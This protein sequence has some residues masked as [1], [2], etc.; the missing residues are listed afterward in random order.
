MSAAPRKKS[1]W[2]GQPAQP[3]FREVRAEI[4]RAAALL[5]LLLFTLAAA[6]P[7][8]AASTVVVREA[9][10]LATIVSDYCG[11]GGPQQAACHA[12]DCCRPDQALLPP[13]PTVIGRAFA[14]WRPIAFAL[15]ADAAQPRAW[16]LPF[17]S[18]APPEPRP[19]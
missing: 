5:S 2:S 19:H 4:A 7:G 16:P 1:R 8:I 15:E 3:T 9:G 11:H 6:T 13:A 10:V 12:P 14:Q 17:R 18:R